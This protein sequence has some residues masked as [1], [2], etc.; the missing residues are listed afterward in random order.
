[1]VDGL[2]MDYKEKSIGFMQ[3][4][5]SD[6]VDGKIQCFPWQNWKEEF[7][8]ANELGISK[9]EWTLDQ[10]NLYKNPLMTDSGRKDIRSLC[11]KYS[12]AIPSLTGDCFMQAP[13][14]KAEGKNKINHQ[15]DFKEVLNAC[16]LIGIKIIVVPLV[17]NGA[18]E[19]QV[20]EDILVNFLKDI[21]SFLRNNDMKIVFESDYSPLLFNKLIRKLDILSFGVNYDIGNSASLGYD[22]NEEFSLFGERIYNVHIKDRPFGK[23]TVPLG[24]GDAD[25]N[26]V[27]GLLES[28]KYSGNLIL[29]TARSDDGNHKGVLEEYKSMVI[30]WIKHNES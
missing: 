5:L 19:S 30:Q 23:T 7:Q 6:I 16:S 3:G 22:P 11:K 14:W 20:Q 18:I 2:Q 17:D 29:Q 26:L 10:K 12:I 21:T 4:R 8:Y 15:N 27:F 13:F 25:F 28:V 9:M 24:E 1:M